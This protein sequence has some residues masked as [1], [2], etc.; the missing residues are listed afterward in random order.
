MRTKH[1]DVRNH[2]LRNSIEEG[3]IRMRYFKTKD[4]IVD[5]FTKALSND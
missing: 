2:F 1:I 3:N 5:I 4:Q